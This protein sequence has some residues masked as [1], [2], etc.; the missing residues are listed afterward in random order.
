MVYKAV[1]TSDGLSIK[2][3]ATGA[4]LQV[5]VIT[6]FPTMVQKFPMILIQWH[7][8]IV[9][10]LFLIVYNHLSLCCDLIP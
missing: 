2:T 10:V 5:D 8:P 4:N 6:S 9:G 3:L 1:A 7:I